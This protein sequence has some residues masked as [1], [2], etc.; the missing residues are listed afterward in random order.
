MALDYSFTDEQ[1]LL[2]QNIHE[3]CKEYMPEEKVLQWH[4]ERGM[5]DEVYKA[6]AKTDFARLGIPAEYGG[7]PCDY[8]T[9]GVMMEELCHSACT[10]VPFVSSTLIIFDVLEFGNDEQIKYCMD[11]YWETGRPPYALAISE[12][13]G[14]SDNMGM[15]TYTKEIDGKIHLNG[16]KTFVTNGEHFPNMIVLAKE[17]DPSRENQSISMWTLPRDYP[18]VEL[19]KLTKIGNQISPFARIHFDDVVIEPDQHL[20][21]RGKGF[22]N[23]MKNFEFERCVIIAMILGEAQA[24]MEDAAAYAAQRMAFGKPI[25][26]YQSVQE[27]L[28]DME[29][30]LRAV[31]EMLYKTLWKMDNNLPINADAAMLKRFGSMALTQ[32]A[33]DALEIF[34]GHGFTTETRVGRAFLDCRGYQL[35]GG[36]REIMS[37]IANRPIIKEYVEYAEKEGKTEFKF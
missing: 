28:V 36:T 22:L 26:K 27:M 13:V 31:R 1:L 3:W 24:A 34:G 30:R 23:L 20:G 12:P 35:G 15:Q 5:D 18:G 32:V 2:K 17:E 29:I 9:L 8:V 37:H 6:W 14:G 19:T 7:T 33:S 21:E 4:D 25:T 10:T 11:T 16:D